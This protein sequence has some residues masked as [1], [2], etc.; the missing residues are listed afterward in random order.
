MVG[1]GFISNWHYEGFKAIPGAKIV[2]LCRDFYGVEEQRIQQKERLEAKCREFGVRCYNSFHEMVEDPELDAL[3]IGS[4]NPY[5]YDQIQR[6]L[7]NGKHVLAE[8]PVV[9]DIEQLRDLIILSKETG[10]IVFPGHNFVYRK[11]V[12]KAKEILDSGK[13]GRLVH[14]SFIVSHT[15]GAGHAAGWRAVKAMGKGG[16]L[17]DSGHHLVYQSLY[18]LGKPIKLHA[19]TSKMVLKNME[20]EDTAQVSMQ[21]SDGSIAVIMQSWTSDHAKNINGIRIL[22][23][24]GEILISDALYLNGEEIEKDTDY[25]DSFKNQARAFKDAVLNGQPPLSSLN[26]VE[27]S[28]RIIYASYESAEK[29]QL[30]HL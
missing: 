10:R 9:T 30:I 24:L 17:M 25:G 22:G 5:H 1:A 26:D 3:L 14:S 7:K 18:L 19:F 11:A 20:C 12:K 8:K 27:E 13:L 6:A 4:I 15:I 28:L 16:A 21:Y 29:D 2:G 23:T